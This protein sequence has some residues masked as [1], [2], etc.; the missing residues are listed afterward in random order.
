MHTALNIPELLEAT[1]LQVEP[2]I[3]LRCRQ[4]NSTFKIAID[5]SPAIQHDLFKTLVL[6]HRSVTVKDSCCSNIGV[7][8][9]SSGQLVISWSRYFD[10]SGEIGAYLHGDRAGRRVYVRESWE[11][12]RPT[13]MTETAVMVR[14]AKTWRLHPHNVSEEAWE[15]EVLAS[16]TLGEIV[17]EMMRRD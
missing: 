9:G 12:L 11:D 6:D 1:L 13:P 7:F 4:V 15:G 10:P 16:Q 17:G 8:H 5:Q 2:R 14:F 3:L